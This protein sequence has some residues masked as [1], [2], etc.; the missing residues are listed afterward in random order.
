MIQTI[1][2]FFMNVVEVLM[3]FIKQIIKKIKMSIKFG[4]DAV[5]VPTI[6]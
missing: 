4:K 6:N 5:K 1:V 2:F 3:P